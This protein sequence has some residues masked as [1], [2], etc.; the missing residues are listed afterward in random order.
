MQYKV[1][2]KYLTSG[3]AAEKDKKNNYEAFS[4]AEMLCV[5]LIMSFIV[6][7][8]PAIH[9]KKTELKTKR[10][11][12]GRYE[13]YYEG[14]QLTQYTVNEEGTAVGPTAV[15]ECKFTPPSNAIFFL[16]HAVGGGGGASSG[17][18]GGGTTACQSK[19]VTAEYSRN[20]ANDFPQ[21]LKDVQGAGKLPVIEEGE[22]YNTTVTGCVAE[23]QYGNGGKAG[24]TLSMF[25]PRLNNVQI[26][27]QPGK[28]GALGSAGAETVVKI[29]DV[30]MKAAG[31][32]GGSGSATETLWFDSTDSICKVTDNASR[33]PDTSDFGT[34]IEMDFGTKMVSQMASACAGGGGAGGFN[35]TN[36]SLIR[37]TVN[38]VDVTAYVKK[39][40]CQAKIAC[41]TGENDTGAAQ[42]GRNGAV[43]ILW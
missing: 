34:S 15:S 7:G 42:T 6:I 1:F 26:T 14:N 39:T 41:A 2:R 4:L 13:C 35:T 3:S 31:G 37:Y 23:V 40:A 20:Q 30:E 18:S 19:T 29:G 43:V 24:E 22:K 28:G 25:F 33:E 8:L 17:V 10:S 9:F 36:G 5:L 27:M 21:W 32:T 38:G 12:H 11:L 16:V